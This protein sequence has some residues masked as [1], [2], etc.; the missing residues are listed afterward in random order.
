[1]KFRQVII[2]AS[3]ALALT[4]CGSGGGGGTPA[5]SKSTSLSDLS[6]S[7]SLKNGQTHTIYAP[8]GGKA[9]ESIT[10]SLASGV[11][12]VT[13][14]T[15]EGSGTGLSVGHTCPSTLTAGGT[16]SCTFLVMFA[17][18][19]STA[20][21]DYTGT[22]SIQYNQPADNDQFHAA[23]IPLVGTTTPSSSTP[24][25]SVALANAPASQS[26]KLAF[27]AYK[28]QQSDVLDLEVKA[29]DTG[30]KFA[31]G[32]LFVAPSGMTLQSS[33]S[34][35]SAG[36]DLTTSGC[37]ITATYNAGSCTDTET[38]SGGAIKY[39][40]TASNTTITQPLNFMR[41]CYAPALAAAF[42][43]DQ[44]LTATRLANTNKSGP[45]STETSVDFPEPFDS[46]SLATMTNYPIGGVLQPAIFMIGHDASGNDPIYVYSSD[47]QKNKVLVASGVTSGDNPAIKVFYSRAEHRPFLLVTSK[48]DPSINIVDPITGAVVSRA[49]GKTSLVNQPMVLAASDLSHGAT[50]DYLFGKAATEDKIARADAAF[51]SASLTSPFGASSGDA[52]AVGKVG[53][54]KP[55]LFTYAATRAAGTNE[56][57]AAPADDSQGFQ[58]DSDL[59]ID[60]TNATSPSLAAN[61][62]YLLL[63]YEKANQGNIVVLHDAD[64]TTSYQWSFFPADVSA[65]QSAVVALTAFGAPLN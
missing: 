26:N 33:A 15:I 43:K 57:Y 35:C 9:L 34:S 54:S 56:V 65:D 44:L 28:G 23:D 1:M 52:L 11:N 37:T 27:A 29:S 42:M 18:N 41:E 38:L 61:D 49:L 19:S 16:S 36:S 63:A 46:V 5:S 21:T 62:S 59:S 48:A 25:V 24:T 14:L 17:P 6:L 50:T 32:S 8:A 10:V 40:E 39:V 22:L 45:V 20:N 51:Q 47:L 2:M 55:M 13:N 12:S 3:V 53:A 4:G 60:L 30:L 7:A 64:G 58:P 31:S